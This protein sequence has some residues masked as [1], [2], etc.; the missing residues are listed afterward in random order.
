MMSKFYQ[1]GSDVNSAIEIHTYAKMHPTP[2]SP[3]I[4][5]G[6]T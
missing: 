6:S 2:L 3:G 1:V 5:V 4:T